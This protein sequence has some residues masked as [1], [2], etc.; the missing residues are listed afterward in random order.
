MYAEYYG[1]STDPFCLSPDP[2]FRLMHPSYRKAKA[3]MQYAL[4]RAEGFILVT[5]AP[6][7]GKTTLIKDMLDELHSTNINVAKLV[8]THVDADDLLRL[9]AYG[10]GIANVGE[11]KATVIRQLEEYLE[12]QCQLQRKNLL[13]VDEAQDLSPNAL[14]E[15]RL[16]TN[17]EQTNQPIL[18]IF[19]VGQQQLLNL[20]RLKNMEQLN[21]RIIAAC[22]LKPLLR[23]HVQPYVVHRLRVVG[24]E[25]DPSIDPGV[26]PLLHRLSEG[27]PRKI[28]QLCSRLLLL[29]Y[30]E[31][32]HHLGVG[33]V[34]K[35]KE[36][37][38]KE[39]P[40]LVG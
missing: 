36:E 33:D 27:I 23:E 15:L 32:K 2:R 35:V 1:L 25:H 5:G 39:Q 6:G 18:Q 10:F 37:L 21:Q 34:L 26:F 9:T 28:N 3:Y 4:S 31:N 30:V 20:V 29:G 14:E 11:H 19:L 24:W 22:T 40:R 13:I 16:L 8:S 12:G 7:T 38:R 17:L